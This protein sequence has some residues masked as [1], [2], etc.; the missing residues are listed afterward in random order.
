MLN[1]SKVNSKDTRTM[2][3]EKTQNNPTIKMTSLQYSAQVQE[4]TG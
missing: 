3:I 4:K 1:I 2:S